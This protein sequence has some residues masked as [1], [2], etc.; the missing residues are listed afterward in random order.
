[1]CASYEQKFRKTFILYTIIGSHKTHTLLPKSALWKMWCKNLCKTHR[2]R[3]VME[4]I[5]GENLSTLGWTDR[6][7]FRIQSNICDRVLLAKKVEINES[8]NIAL[9]AVRESIKKLLCQYLALLN[10]FFNRFCPVEK[11]G[12]NPHCLN[13]DWLMLHLRYSNGFQIFL[14]SAMVLQSIFCQNSL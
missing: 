13:R 4:S 6:G 1:M 11:C 12:I 14:V 3:L 9:F 8:H 10:M 5:V 2:K 7:I